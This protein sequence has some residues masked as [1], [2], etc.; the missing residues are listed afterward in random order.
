MNNN[1]ENMN[2]IE[3]ME[4]DIIEIYPNDLFFLIMCVGYIIDNGIKMKSSDESDENVNLMIKK[5]LKIIQIIDSFTK[6][7]DMTNRYDLIDIIINQNFKLIINMSTFFC[8]TF[9]KEMKEF[10][11]NSMGAIEDDD[12]IKQKENIYLD[13]CNDLMKCYNLIDILS[14]KNMMI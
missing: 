13:G 1:I 2:S 11:Q 6:K 7:K 3:N 14:K 9:N 12:K 10:V 4:S 8:K 5:F